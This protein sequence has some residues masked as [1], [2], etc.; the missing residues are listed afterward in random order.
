MDSVRSSLACPL[1]FAERPIS[2]FVQRL[3]H[4]SL[5]MISSFLG[6]AASE[7][8]IGGQAI[9]EGVMMRGKRKVSLA[10]KT[11]TGNVAVEL[12]PF[13]SVMLKYPML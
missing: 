9:I 8:K 4:Q 1:F 11:P 6:L 2:M 5:C 13:V 10:V 12:I 3:F 7:P